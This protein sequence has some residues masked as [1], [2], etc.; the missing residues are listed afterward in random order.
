MEITEQKIIKLCKKNKREGFELLFTKYEKYIYKICYSYTYKKEDALDLVQDIFIRIYKSFEKVDPDK[1][2]LPW[3]RKI[4]VNACLNYRRDNK[5]PDV[6]INS[7]WEEDNS[8]EESIPG[9]VTLEEEVIYMDTKKVLEVSIKELPEDVRMAVILR[10]IKDMSYNDIAQV[11]RC[12]VGTIKTYIFRGRRML[13]EKLLQK[14]I[15][16]V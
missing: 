2:I 4:T 14:G 7:G 11:M 9:N 3:I 16:E 1:P 13:K 12:P 6:S 15:W 10:H 8:I 5:E